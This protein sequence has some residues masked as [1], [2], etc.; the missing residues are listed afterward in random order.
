MTDVEDDLISML[1]AIAERDDGGVLIDSVGLA[2]RLGWTDEQTAAAL[3]TA[4]DD[5]LV[6][7]I[8]IGGIP[9]PRFDEI[10]LTVQG[11][12]RLHA[13]GSPDSDA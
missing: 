7:G 5:H 6:W 12:R 9:A 8:R 2:R 4:K 13:A 3:S 1:R 11:R 10:E